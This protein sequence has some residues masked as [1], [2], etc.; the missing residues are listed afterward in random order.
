M[1]L[2][3]S[4]TAVEICGAGI[5]GKFELGF[6]AV[7]NAQPLHQ[8]RGES[9][10]GAT[11][12]AVEDEETLKTGA[13]VGKFSNAVE[14]KVDDFLSNGVVTTGVIVGRVLLSTDQLFWMEK[15]SISSST[16]FIWNGRYELELN[17]EI[18]RLTPF[19]SQISSV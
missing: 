5:N 4:T 13:L 18:H 16:D 1:E 11:T 14:Y 6:L 9:R 19:A 7:V 17:Q 10:T 8:Q 2:Y 12:K 3:G 15:L